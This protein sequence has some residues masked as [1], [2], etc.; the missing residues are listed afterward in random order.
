MTVNGAIVNALAPTGVPCSTEPSTAPDATYL[1]F[2]IIKTPS[3]FADDEPLYS[4]CYCQVHL[5]CP[6]TLNTLA[7]RKQ[8]KELLFASGFS[9]PEE[10]DAS[11]P[12]KQHIVFGFYCSVETFTEEEV[13]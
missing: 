5:F 2:N 1:T 4:I 11:E 6:P 8:I 9:Y 3:Y 7:L 13:L 10:E 12:E